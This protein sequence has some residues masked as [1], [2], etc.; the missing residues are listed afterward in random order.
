MISLKSRI[1]ILSSVV[2]LVVGCETRQVSA[3]SS[4]H[5][6]N[7]EPTL[8]KLEISKLTIDA[9]TGNSIPSAEKLYRYYTF[10]GSNANVSKSH[11][12]LTWLADRGVPYAQFNLGK[13]LIDDRKS[14]Q[15]GLNLMQKAHEGG[16]SAGDKLFKKY[17]LRYGVK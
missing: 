3:P 17:T 10:S 5:N 8:S 2:L 16:Y 7:G 9:K 11:F 12:W 15:E 13:E 6:L 14:T 1:A 4:W